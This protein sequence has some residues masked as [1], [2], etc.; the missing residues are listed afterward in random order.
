MFSVFKGV[1]ERDYPVEIYD[2]LSPSAS[3]ALSLPLHQVL[4]AMK[5]CTDKTRPRFM[6]IDVE[7]AGDIVAVYNN[8]ITHEAQLF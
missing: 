5:S 1:L 4:C 2:P 8:S 3:R 7:C 6:G